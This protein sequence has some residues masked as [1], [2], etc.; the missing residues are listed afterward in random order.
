[1]RVSCLS[2]IAIVAVL[3]PTVGKAQAYPLRTAPP[4]VTAATAD[5]QLNNETIIVSSTLFQPTRAFRMFDGQVMVQVGV[6]Q[7]VPLYADV[8]LE[9]NSIIYVQEVADIT[10]EII[11][12]VD[13]AVAKAPA[14]APA[15]PVKK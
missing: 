8:T 3:V 2:L 11:R 14:A 5:W 12:R 9:P 13:A 4:E 10:T 7:R 15:A 1:M 6:Y